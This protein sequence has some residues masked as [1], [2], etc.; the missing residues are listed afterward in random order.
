MRELG[1]SSDK[2]GVIAENKEKYISFKTKVV[3]GEYMDKKGEIK[4]KE[5]QLR[6]INSMRFMVSS[7]DSL[8]NNLVKSGQHLTGFEDY[9]TIRIAYKERCLPI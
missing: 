2:T 4:D 6:F 5:I 8:T 7:L 1:R 3:I 9:T